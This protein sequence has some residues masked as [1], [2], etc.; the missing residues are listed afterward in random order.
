MFDEAEDLELEDSEF[1]GKLESVDAI[2]EFCLGGNARVTV[3]SVRTGKRFTFR[4][5]RKR[6]AEPEDSYYV[7]VLRGS[8][9]DTDFVYIGCL[10]TLSVDKQL[11]DFPT[12]QWTKKS[13]IKQ[14]AP[15]VQAFKWFWK[16]V[17]AGEMPPNAEVW[18][19]GRCGCCGRTLTV[20]ESV[21]RGIGPECAMKLHVANLLDTFL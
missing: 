16:F 6:D 18:H 12:F 19:E 3:K 11:L 21:A 1:K 10:F 9:N 8:N 4:I 7:Y 15:S 5:F 20:P 17:Y 2:R 14:D 13:V